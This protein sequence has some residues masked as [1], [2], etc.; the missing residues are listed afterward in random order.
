MPPKEELPWGR[1]GVN[2]IS[3]TTSSEKAKVLITEPVQKKLMR[4]QVS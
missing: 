4:D 2:Q 1:N 3:D